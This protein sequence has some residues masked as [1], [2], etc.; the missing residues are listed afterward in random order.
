MNADSMFTSV[1]LKEDLINL[2]HYKNNKNCMIFLS[3]LI[4]V[5]NW[6]YSLLASYFLHLNILQFNKIEIISPIGFQKRVI[7][8][9][10]HKTKQNHLDNKS[11]YAE[12]DL[13]SWNTLDTYAIFLANIYSENEIKMNDEDKREIRWYW[14]IY[15][16]I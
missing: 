13:N 5:D 3:S 10:S 4:T 11:Y 16:L 1:L 9:F 12:D 7:G 15:A 8:I 6:I 2:N 14:E